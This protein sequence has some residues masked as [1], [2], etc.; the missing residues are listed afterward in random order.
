MNRFTLFALSAVACTACSDSASVDQGSTGTSPTADTS[1][2]PAPTDPD[3][4]VVPSG[5][6]LALV[7]PGGALAD[8]FA[9]PDLVGECDSC[10]GEGA[11]ADGDALLVAIATGAGLSDGIARV[12]PDG[13]LDFRVDGFRF[14]HD[15][16]RDPADGTLMVVETFADRVV[17]IDGSGSSREALREIGVPSTPEMVAQP[18]GAELVN[19]GERRYLLLSHVGEVTAPLRPAGK[20]T[21]WDITSPGA[22]AHVWSYPPD[23]ALAGR[24]VRFFAGSVLSGGCCGRTPRGPAGGAPWAWRSPRTWPPCRCMWPT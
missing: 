22:L 20:I 19:T 14:P 10:A 5:T 2:G 11:S 13:T 12:F 16:I 23:G 17:W 24:T 4:L 9:W 7:Y 18:N 21:L 15:V 1:S 8:H 6:G 3:R